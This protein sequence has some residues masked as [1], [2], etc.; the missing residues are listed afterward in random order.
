[1]NK[2]YIWIYVFVFFSDK[3]TSLGV[4]NLYG[5]AAHKSH[6]NNTNSINKSGNK[7][8]YIL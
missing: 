3:P 5:M 8:L 1:M 4:R 7:L 6:S 2:Y